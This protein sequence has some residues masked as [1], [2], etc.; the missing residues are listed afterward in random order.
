MRRN[1]SQASCRRWRRLH[2][3]RKE[4]PLHRLSLSIISI[5]LYLS[6]NLSVL[7]KDL[8]RKWKYKRKE[9]EHLHYT[10]L[11]DRKPSL[12]LNLLPFQAFAGVFIGKRGFQKTRVENR[13]MGPPLCHGNT[14]IA[15]FH[16]KTRDLGPWFWR[17]VSSCFEN[18][19]DILGFEYLLPDFHQTRTNV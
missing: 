4:T 12:I 7:L 11:K 17:A 3:R 8:K 16:G 13:R 15:A 5:S 18:L 6:L 2:W 9:Q 19:P 1:T 10:T 14:A